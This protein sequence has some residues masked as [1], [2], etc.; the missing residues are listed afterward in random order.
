[1]V[2]WLVSFGADYC[3][4]HI[5]GTGIDKTVGRRFGTGQDV[6]LDR[7]KDTW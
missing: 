6:A 3:N 4:V 5:R 2:N 7:E 1:M